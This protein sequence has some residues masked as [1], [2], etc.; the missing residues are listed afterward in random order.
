MEINEAHLNQALNNN[1][2]AVQE[3]FSGN[4][5]TQ[6]I[7]ERISERTEEFIRYNGLVSRRQESLS[8]QV[9]R[10]DDR[11]NR[12]NVRM[13]NRE[14]NLVQQFARMEMALNEMQ[15]QG[16]ELSG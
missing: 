5:S 9:N 3:L 15:V 2:E 11:I 12:E 8:N 16:A 13:E 1:P 14:Q 6:G 10:I 4:E 7:A